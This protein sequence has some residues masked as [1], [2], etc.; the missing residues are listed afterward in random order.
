MNIDCA[1]SYIS[2]LITIITVITTIALGIQVFFI[3]F[4]VKQAIK[5]VK[6]DNE[7]IIDNIKNEIKI[8]IDNVKNENEKLAKKI[9]KNENESLGQ[10]NF[11]FGVTT[12]SIVHLEEAIKYYTKTGNKKMIEQCNNY[13]NKIK[14]K[15]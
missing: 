4:Y 8:I 12:N 15:K 6:R 11:T 10:A 1:M 7:I 3:I 5:K 14:A 2:I 9:I 13:I